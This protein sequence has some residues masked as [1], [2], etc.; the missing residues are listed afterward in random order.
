MCTITQ[1]SQNIEE[2]HIFMCL[3]LLCKMLCF[4]TTQTRSPQKIC[5]NSWFLLIRFCFIVLEMLKAKYAKKML[6]HT[7][8]CV[9]LWKSYLKKSICFNFYTQTLIV[10]A[11][12]VVIFFS[13]FVITRTPLLG[14]GGN[15]V[16]MNPTSPSD[17][18]KQPRTLENDQKTVHKLCF[19][20]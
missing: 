8:K 18:S 20:E 6:K 1:S 19:C 7:H 15:L 4:T 10:V 14:F 11:F 3:H 2:T 12:L 16:E 5:L 13:F 17:L 9:R